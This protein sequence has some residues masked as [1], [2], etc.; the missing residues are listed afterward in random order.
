MNIL[1]ISEFF[2][3]ILQSKLCMENIKIA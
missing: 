3:S 2:Q 1:V